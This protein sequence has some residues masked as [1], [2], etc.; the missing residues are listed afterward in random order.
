[1]NLKR[2]TNAKLIVVLREK[3]H[4]RYLICEKTVNRIGFFKLFPIKNVGFQTNVYLKIASLIRS[5]LLLFKLDQVETAIREYLRAR[6]EF[7]SQAPLFAS[8]SNNNLGKRLSTRSIRGIV[9]KCFIAAGYN[10][11]TLHNP[12]YL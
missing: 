6:K 8:T 1:M 10:R 7:N 9:K 4:V 5:L 11:L 12:V 3:K 2:V